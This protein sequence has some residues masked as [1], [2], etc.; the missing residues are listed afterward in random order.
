MTGF[1][2]SRFLAVLRKEWLQ[3]RR[4]PATIS[5][6]VALPLIQL[7]LFGYA[8]NTN[9]RHL[10][11]AVLAA[12]QSRYVRTLEAALVNTGYFT[13]HRYDSEADA[14]LAIRRGEV[15][16]VLSIPPNFGRDIDR[17]VQPQ[18]L[19]AADA[20]DPT[21][22]AYASAAL[23]ALNATVMQRD[24][25]PSL[26]QQPSSPPFGVVFH[27]RYNPEYVTA[28]NIVPG[29]IGTILTLSTLMLTA[30]SMTKEREGGTM[31]NLLAMPVRP[32]E[33]MLGKIIP[34][35]GLG[36]TQIMLI[37]AVAFLVFRVPVEGSVL[38]LL[39]VL[40]LFILCNLALGFT[41]ST[42]A[43]TQM[44]ALQMAQFF[45]LP[46]MLL[47]GF[48]FPFHGMPGW[49]QAV[50]ET[51][52]LTHAMRISR[53]ILLKGN[54]V[55]EIWPDVWPLVL[56]AVVAVVVAVRSFRETLD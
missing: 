22:I 56:F 11:T 2:I 42:L 53:G 24:L 55:V 17:G 49:A 43:A 40:G 26:R 36:Y 34:Y 33:V 54:G 39:G 25:P 30:L 21:A 13:L 31:E 47:S 4:D 15:L 41:F 48:I 6:T 18:V 28:L 50:G 51:P 38:L 9:P 1:S 7:F 19:M 10:P 5:L 32:L 29:L 45:F 37:L 12:D 3:M 35:V 8:L 14:E 23:S 20:T 44:Q 27:A 16:F 52:P 46:S